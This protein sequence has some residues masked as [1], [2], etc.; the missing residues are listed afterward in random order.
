MAF[1]NKKKQEEEQTPELV[2]QAK[3][4]LLTM[5]RNKVISSV[6][7]IILGVVLLVWS[8]AALNVACQVIGAVLAVGGVVAVVMFLVTREKTF[9]SYSGLAVGVIIAVLGLW[10]FFNPEFLVKLVPTILGIMVIISGILNLSETWTIHKENGDGMWIAFVMALVTIALGCLIVIHPAAIAKVLIKIMGVVM[11]YNG[12]SDLYIISRITGTVKEV[13]K[14]VKEAEQEAEAVDTAAADI[15]VEDA[16]PAPE[17]KPGKEAGYTE[18]PLN[19][20]HAEA[21]AAPAPEAAQQ[22]EGQAAPET[23]TDASSQDAQ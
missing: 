20:N 12:L 1:W 2:K 23:E 19:H 11:V 17:A 22:A 9:I 3:K 15:P 21:A 10:L 5:K 4:D 8:E 14:A 13:K 6:V 7:F 18:V 16:A